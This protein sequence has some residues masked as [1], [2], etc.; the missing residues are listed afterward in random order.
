MQIVQD[1]ET[2][3][4]KLSPKSEPIFDTREQAKNAWID[5]RM[6]DIKDSLNNVR[7]KRNK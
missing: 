2:G 5:K 3:K 6:N 4:W 1:T 7:N